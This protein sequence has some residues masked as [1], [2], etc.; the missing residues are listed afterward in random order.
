M[1]TVQQW[2]CDYVYSVCAR[3]FDCHSDL[4]DIK[5]F[6]IKLNQLNSVTSLSSTRVVCVCVC[7]PVNKCVCLCMCAPVRRGLQARHPG[8]LWLPEGWSGGVRHRG[9]HHQPH[10]HQRL[11][12]RAARPGH[13]LQ[14]KQPVRLWVTD[15]QP[16][17]KVSAGCFCFGVLTC[18]SVVTTLK[19][20]FLIVYTLNRMGVY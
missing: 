10:L 4:W 18:V 1:G 3:V 2:T 12:A 16:D 11:R 15:S 8:F 6:Q 13:R 19:Y 14:T 20:L 17:K 5:D 7:A 9:E